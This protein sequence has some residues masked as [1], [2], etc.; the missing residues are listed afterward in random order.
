MNKLKSGILN[1]SSNVI[2]DSTE[3]ANFPHKFTL[4]D[5]QVFRFHKDSVNSSSAN[6]KL[7]KTQPFK[8]VQ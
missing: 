3:K 4:T 6:L 1:V 7:L 5:F 2:G 8:I